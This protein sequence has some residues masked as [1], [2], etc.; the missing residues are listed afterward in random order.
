MS[1]HKTA[2]K[3]LVWQQVKKKA[4][5]KIREQMANIFL[6]K[7]DTDM[8][9]SVLTQCTE[10][11]SNQIACKCSGA[12]HYE[13]A[14]AHLM[15]TE[16]TVVCTKQTFGPVGLI[17]SFLTPICSC[18]MVFAL[19]FSGQPQ[20]MTQTKACWSSIS[21]KSRVRSQRGLD[22]GRTE[23]A[24]CW[25]SVETDICFHVWVI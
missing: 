12:K 3:K 20:Q 1:W 6:G 8:C 9:T 15:W 19:T 5:L 25:S 14:G 7:K 24:C 23:G 21:K 17:L 10:C 22:S 13:R 4:D 2:P 11:G 18:Q 16:I